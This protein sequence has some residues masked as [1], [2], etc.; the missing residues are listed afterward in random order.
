MSADDLI[1]FPHLEELQFFDNNLVT[2]D[3]NLF[4]NNPTLRLINFN[5]NFLQEI[6]NELIDG[7][8]QLELA[9]FI[10]NHCIDLIATNELNFVEL[11]KRFVDDC[12]TA[13]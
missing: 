7:S 5:N 10:T 3:G 12:S 11:R 9:S 1:Q 13:P 2:L 6:G 4:M 8:N